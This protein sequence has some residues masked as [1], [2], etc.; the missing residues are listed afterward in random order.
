MK[1]KWFKKDLVIAL[2][3][4]FI[5]SFIII[6]PQIYKR[7]IILGTDVMF[8]LNRFFET[9]KQLETGKFNY[10]LSLFSFNSSGRIVNA[11]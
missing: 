3:V 6:S 4:I 11:F 8:H 10:F 5:C 7:S 1:M 2:V 9:A